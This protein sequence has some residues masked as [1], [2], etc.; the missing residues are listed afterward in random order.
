MLASSARCGASRRKHCS[1]E[2]SCPGRAEWYGKG[3]RMTSTSGHDRDRLFKD[4][5]RARDELRASY[6][7]LS[8]DQMTPPG[9]VG[10]WSVRDV[11]SHI[12]A[13]DEMVLPELAR[14]SRGDTPTLPS[15]DPGKI[16]DFNA[17]LV[18]L[19][20]NLPLAQVLRELDIARSDVM[21]ALGRL[22][23]SALVEGQFGRT[24]LQIWAGHDK[25]HA[26]HIRQWRSKQG[27]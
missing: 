13:W 23:D 17:M 14:L 8:D 16:D 4:L 20:R 1:F 3:T 26:E 24:L 22:P 2:S 11:L 19:R 18:S 25:E 5:E 12:A 10:D 9:A 21:V 6:Q 27:L 15:L 7:G